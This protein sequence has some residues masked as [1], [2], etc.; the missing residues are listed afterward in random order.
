MFYLNCQ[1]F[2]KVMN[3]NSNIKMACNLNS[4]PTYRGCRDII[5]N[6]RKYIYYCA[7]IISAPSKATYIPSDINRLLDIID[8]LVTKLIQ[9]D[10]LQKHLS[11]N[12]TRIIIQLKYI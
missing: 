2:N 3:L 5:P 6:E 1:Y 11:V 8:I 7:C 10:I 4:K 9:Y 12:Y